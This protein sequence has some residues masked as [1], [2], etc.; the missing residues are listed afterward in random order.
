MS[1]LLLAT[2]CT[3][4]IALQSESFRPEKIC[5][6]VGVSLSII[7]DKAWPKQIILVFLIE[8]KIFDQP[9]R[10]AST[11][12]AAKCNHGFNPHVW[13]SGQREVYD[14]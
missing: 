7:L 3:V 13:A 12:R 10:I 1:E 5:S 4:K 14:C 11:H 6:Q 2:N 9:H 8:R